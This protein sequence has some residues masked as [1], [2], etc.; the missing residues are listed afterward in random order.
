MKGER[1]EQ[2]NKHRILG[3]IFDERMTWNE[4]ILYAEA[5]AENK[6]N[7]LKYLR[8]GEEVY[9]SATQAILR[10]LEPTH[11][12]GVK[13][14]L[15][16][17]VICRTENALCEANIPTLA[18][19]RELNNVKTTIRMITNPIHPMRPLSIDPNITDEYAYRVT[20]PKP[21]HVRAAE[22]FGKLQIDPRRIEQTPPHHRP[23]W[24][25]TAN[26]QYDLKLCS[27][28]HGA[29]GERFRQETVRILNKIN[30]K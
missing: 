5:K 17:F 10:K 7:I 24:I 2:V 20:T 23:Q 14:A 26:N 1:I 25:E 18:E 29:I 11:N 16:I 22:T 3:L 19:I 9:G 8:Y 6:M 12:R 13:L 27:I 21:L 30:K 4:H 28:G 15:V